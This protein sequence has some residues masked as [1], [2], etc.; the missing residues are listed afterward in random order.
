MNYF[1]Y[2]TRVKLRIKTDCQQFEM[3]EENVNPEVLANNIDLKPVTSPSNENNSP[4]LTP[5]QE[6]EVDLV[7]LIFYI[8]MN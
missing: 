5:E 7:C 1:F 8:T 6:N 3:K 4:H 2:F